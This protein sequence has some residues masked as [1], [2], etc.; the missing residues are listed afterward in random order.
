MRPMISPTKLRETASGLQR[1]SVLSI[2]I[3]PPHTS[4]KAPPPMAHPY[5]GIASQLAGTA[6]SRIRYVEETA[7]TNADASALL[8][9]EG[10]DGLT[11]VAEYQSSGAG[12]KG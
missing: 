11:I 5:A 3:G 6:F 12:R 8:G 9:S 7:S 4:R 10:V 2:A 1:I